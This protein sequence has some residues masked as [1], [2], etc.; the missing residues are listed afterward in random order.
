[1]KNKQDNA[2]TSL[3]N[4]IFKRKNMK[5]KANCQ[6]RKLAINKTIEI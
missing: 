1:M 3:N 6:N 4:C 5:R 2:F